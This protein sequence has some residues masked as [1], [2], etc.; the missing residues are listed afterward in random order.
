MIY[1]PGAVRSLSVE[2]ATRLRQNV[3]MQ[4]EISDRVT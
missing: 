3:N 1:V 2:K 4:I